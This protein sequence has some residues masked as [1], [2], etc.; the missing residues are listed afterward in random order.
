VPIQ[1]I[2]TYHI[3][4]CNKKEGAPLFAKGQKAY[5]VWDD[6][7]QRFILHKSRSEVTEEELSGVYNNERLSGEKLIEHNFAELSK[8]AKLGDPEQKRWLRVFLTSLKDSPQKLAL[9]Q[10]FKEI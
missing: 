10:A 1:F 3:T 7:K 5:Y 4:D 9:Q 6:G 8:I 2:L